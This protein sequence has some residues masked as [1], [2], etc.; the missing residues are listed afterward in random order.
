MSQVYRTFFGFPKETFASDLKAEE[1][2]K[3]QPCG[4]PLTSYTPFF[5]FAE[6]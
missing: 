2:L 3:T 6:S 1:I 5:Q 4:I